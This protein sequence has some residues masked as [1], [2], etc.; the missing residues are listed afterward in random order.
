MDLANVHVFI[1]GWEG[2]L[3]RARDIAAALAPVVPR[4]T[5]VYSN[6]A[7]SD[8]EGPG[9]WLRVSNADFFGKKFRCCL[10]AFTGGTFLL[11]HA[12]TDFHDWALLVRRCGAVFVAL[13]GIG[14]WTPQI[15]NSW[16]RN[17]AVE[18]LPISEM[19]GLVSVAQTDGIVFALAPP[20]I[21]RLRQFDYEVNNLGWGI[22]L[23]AVVCARTAG[24]LVCCDTTLRVAHDKSRG[25]QD[26]AAFAQMRAFQ[27]QFTL[28]ELDQLV[29]LRSYVSGRM[30]D[31]NSWR[32]RILRKLGRSV[33]ADPEVWL[34]G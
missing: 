8:V 30:R 2:K 1:I 10:E 31:E 4:V 19:P 7:E 12:D 29:M 34:R 28:P 9:D 32:A 21:D 6:S 26:D 5:V 20:V 15:S 27:T 16:W 24:L 11:I 13:P 3:D 18:L 17:S 22:D 33:R 14:V 23:G 25:Y